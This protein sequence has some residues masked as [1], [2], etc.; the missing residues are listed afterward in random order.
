M[1][2]SWASSSTMRIVSTLTAQTRCKVVVEGQAE[3]QVDGVLLAVLRVVQHGLSV[4]EN[5]LGGD[6]YGASFSI[7]IAG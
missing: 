3:E 4:G 1:D 2:V 5:V 6:G 7:G